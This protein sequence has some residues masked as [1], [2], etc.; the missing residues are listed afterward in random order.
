MVEEARTVALRSAEL[1][2]RIDELCTTGAQCV[3]PQAAACPTGGS[4]GTAA[5][6]AGWARR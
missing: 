2:G 5:L 1:L 6:P 4:V 3:D